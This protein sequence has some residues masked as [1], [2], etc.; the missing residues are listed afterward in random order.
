MV[1]ASDGLSLI[2]YTYTNTDT[3]MMTVDGELNK[4]AHNI[5]YGHGLHGGI[6]WRTDSDDSML[7]GEAVATS[8]LQDKAHTYNEDFEVKFTKLDGTTA[9]IKKP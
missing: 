5:T 9:T 6:H 7:L 1:P 4:L 3:S 2:P 8:F